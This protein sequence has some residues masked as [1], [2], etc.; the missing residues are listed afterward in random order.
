MATEVLLRVLT[1]AV[2]L[3]AMLL[4]GYYR[5]R[6]D[7]GEKLDRKQ[8]GWFLLIAIRLCGLFLWVSVIVWIVSPSAIAGTAI[9]LPDWARFVGFPLGVAAAGWIV[10]VFRSLGSNLT[11]TVVTR[12]KAYLVTDRGPYRW[13][14]HPLYTAIIP[15]GVSFSLL[16]A[17]WRF[18]VVAAATFVLLRFRTAIEERNLVSRF[19]DDY[20]RYMARTGRFLPR[21]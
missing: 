11:D 9:E 13:I 16:T 21:T 4:G 15:M 17:N 2:I 14:R 10:W 5:R 12:E 8:E 19:G 20:R 1:A 6:S 3:G 7:S 18:A